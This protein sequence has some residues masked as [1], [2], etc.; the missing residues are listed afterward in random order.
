M[1]EELVSMACCA[2]CLRVSRV[3]EEEEDVGDLDMWSFGELDMWFCI[4]VRRQSG[5]EGRNALSERIWKL[6][7]EAQQPLQFVSFCRGRSLY[8]VSDDLVSDVISTFCP[9]CECQWF[10]GYVYPRDPGIPETTDAPYRRPHHDSTTST[11]RQHTLAEH[12]GLGRNSRCR[13]VHADGHNF[14]G[15]WDL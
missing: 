10:F 13:Y 3:D 6:E 11:R 14:T 5:D 15:F 9:K 4:D 7:R 12:T 1:E 2:C 8:L